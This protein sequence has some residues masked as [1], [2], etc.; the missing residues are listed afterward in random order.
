MNIE[1]HT[2]EVTSANFSPDIKIPLI[3]SS[4]FDKTVKIWDKKSGELEKT[5]EGHTDIVTFVS[6]SPNGKHLVSS[7]K[8]KTVKI[9]DIEYSI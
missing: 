8:D 2:Q 1:G 7:S 9:W 3:A 4:S 6:F 5:L